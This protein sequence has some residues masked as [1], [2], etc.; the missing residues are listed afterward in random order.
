VLKH[1]LI[2]CSYIV[3]AVAVALVLPVLVPEVT[4]AVGAVAGGVTLVAGALAHESWA[5]VEAVELN[6]SRLFRL[7]GVLDRVR[8]ENLRFGCMIAA[9]TGGGE[10]R[11]ATDLDR[12][13]SEVR[14][15][16]KLIEQLSPR[17]PRKAPAQ[18]GEGVSDTDN[19]G[20][21]RI[22]DIVRE[23]LKRDRVDLYLQPIAALPERKARFYECFSRIRAADGSL[24]RPEQYIAIAAREGLVGAIDNLL[25]FRCVQLVR[26]AQKADGNVGFFC[27]ISASTLKDRAFFSDFVDVMAANTG[28]ARNLIF[29]FSQ[30]DVESSRAEMEEYIFRLGRLGFSF[31]IDRVHDLT[32]LDIPALAKRRFRYIKIDSAQMLQRKAVADG[33]GAEGGGTAVIEINVAAL[34]RVLQAYG[35]ELIAE[36]IESEDDLAELLGHGI[37]YGQGYLFGVPSPSRDA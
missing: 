32:R 10:P 24:V 6:E 21:R 33:V 22:L 27:N 3:L 26:R 1:G 12:V 14:V 4:P 37:D 13:V 2:S 36:K 35:I 17:R 20:D 11:K 25:L 34:K 15:L 19:A 30:D 8:T 23:G 28:L 18:S 16:Q 5:R 29:E 31:S 7:R 9:L